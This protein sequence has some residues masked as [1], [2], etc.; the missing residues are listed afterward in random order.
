MFFFKNIFL[1]FLDST[2]IQWMRKSSMNTI[3]MIESPSHCVKYVL[4]VSGVYMYPYSLFKALTTH[5]VYKAL[6]VC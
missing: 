6:A 4:V 5:S 3:E 1:L 2:T